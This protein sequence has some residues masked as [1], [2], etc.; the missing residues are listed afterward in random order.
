MGHLAHAGFA[1][2]GPE[3]EQDVFVL[4]VLLYRAQRHALA[5]GRVLLDVEISVGACGRR[6]LHLR[7]EAAEG[8]RRLV[9]LQLLGQCVERGQQLLR[10]HGGGHLGQERQAEDVVAVLF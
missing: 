5:F 7:G 2:R 10:A 6:S 9:A 4:R 1:P 8:G 3:V